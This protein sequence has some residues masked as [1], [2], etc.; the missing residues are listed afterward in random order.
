MFHV[1]AARP[2]LFYA[3]TLRTFV[4]IQV[5]VPPNL[6]FCSGRV[7]L[8]HFCIGV[9][10]QLGYSVAHCKQRCLDNTLGDV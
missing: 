4:L 7:I 10:F 3:S 9:S 1:C 2:L 8:R 5:L 6:C